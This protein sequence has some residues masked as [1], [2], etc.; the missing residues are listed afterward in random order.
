[1]R[2][3]I[4]GRVAGITREDGVSGRGVAEVKA[5]AAR[6]ARRRG[7]RLIVPFLRITPLERIGMINRADIERVRIS[8]AS[9]FRAEEL[10]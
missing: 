2:D 10:L 9:R 8:H 6:A 1:M 5:V 4:E 3:V 7:G